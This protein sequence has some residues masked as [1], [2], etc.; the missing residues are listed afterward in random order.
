MWFTAANGRILKYVPTDEELNRG[1]DEASTDQAPSETPAPRSVAVK[2]G[3]TEAFLSWMTVPG[4]QSYN[5]YFNTIPKLT[6]QTATKIEGV[7]NP[8]THTG[9]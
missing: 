7:T 2:A 5:L 3:D 9:L 1:K 4:A 6:T 8:Y